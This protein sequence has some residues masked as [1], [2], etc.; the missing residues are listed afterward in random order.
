M[1]ILALVLAV[2]VFALTVEAV[3]GVVNLPVVLRKGQDIRRRGLTV[4]VKGNLTHN[5]DDVSAQSYDIEVEAG[6]PPQKL[7][8]TL[9]S[10]ESETWLTSPGVPPCHPDK[11]CNQW[12]FGANLSSTFSGTSF[13]SGEASFGD[14]TTY[15]PSNETFYFNLYED[16]FSIAGITIPKQRFG[17]QIPEADGTDAGGGAL[18]L[19]PHLHYGYEA[20]K[21]FNTVLDN[22]AAQGAIASRTY[23]LDVGKYG[24]KTGTILFGGADTGRFSGELVKRPLVKDELGTWGASVVLTGYGQ[25]TTNGSEFGYDVSNG[26]SVFLLDITNQYLRL[27]HS[28]VD[29]L[30]RDMG[31]VNDGNDA[32][33]VDCTWRDQPGSWD[34]QFGDAKIKIPYSSLVTELGPDEEGK[35]CW[36]AILVTLKGQ[37]VL[38]APFFQASYVSFDLDN[39][40]VGLAPSATCGSNIVAF[41][42]GADAI[43]QLTGCTD[44]RRPCSSRAH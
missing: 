3:P 9:V 44:G 35:L 6:T 20:G 4:P 32:Y 39:Q 40:Q 43:P 21:P 24:D 11:P 1:R 8:F 37:L 22:M 19:G 28:F 7:R 38:G 29:T 16:D 41:G 14:P 33:Y 42:A 18:G 26:D 27:R 30:L 36:L 15:P 17:I 10:S 13:G 23:S 12:H 2:A 34:L 31:A 25:T 5:Q